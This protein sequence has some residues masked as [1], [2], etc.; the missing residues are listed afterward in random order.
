[1]ATLV[2]GPTRTRV[3]GHKALLSYYSSF[4]NAEFYRSSK[5]AE[6][7][8]IE[9]P[10][11]SEEDLAAFVHWCFT[12]DVFASHDDLPNAGLPSSLIEVRFVVSWGPTL[13][14]KVLQ[15]S[16]TC[17]M[18]GQL[19]DRRHCPV[20]LRQYHQRLTTEKVSEDKQPT[21]MGVLALADHKS[22]KRKLIE[23][24]LNEHKGT[25]RAMLQGQ[26]PRKSSNL[27]D[28]HRDNLPNQRVGQI[29]SFS[30][31]NVSKFLVRS[32]ASTRLG[33]HQVDLL[34]ILLS[35]P[36]STSYFEQENSTRV[37]TNEYNLRS[38][39]VPSLWGHSDSITTSKK[40]F[41]I[42]ATFEIE[43]P[44]DEPED[45]RAFVNWV[46]TG[47][48]LSCHRH[49]GDPRA[50]ELN[51]IFASNEIPERIWVLGDK[52]LATGFT[53]D[54]MRL[55]MRRYEKLSSILRQ[56]LTLRK[57][58]RDPISVEGTLNAEL[59]SKAN[60]ENWLVV[61]AK[62]GDLVTECIID[63]FNN[64]DGDD[65]RPYNGNNQDKYLVEVE[66]FPVKEW[67]ENQKKRQSSTLAMP[68]CFLE[69]EAY[70]ATDHRGPTMDS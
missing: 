61:L 68:I 36:T 40:P 39:I 4:F 8:E 1:M 47:N 56:L 30:R 43:L 6:Q 13:G 50:H 18:L 29:V 23:Y 16:S 7:K 64:F 9:L 67:L 51:H 19:C 31:T 17:P 35:K 42:L 52:L 38:Q 66:T 57:S 69:V 11:E 53:N 10:E 41:Q 15:Q 65:E 63:G 60:I 32:R 33:S 14:A 37:F 44:D 5:E 26:P 22:S 70:T 48:I 58:I 20:L 3:R 45:M 49:V 28:I 62:G 2:V 12:G 27:E 21:S 54:A 25:G 34:Q 24:L 55:L 59:S 46:Y